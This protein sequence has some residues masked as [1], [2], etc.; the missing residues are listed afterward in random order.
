[1][2]RSCLTPSICLAMILGLAAADSQA[3]ADDVDMQTRMSIQGSPQMDA[4]LAVL[5]S[6]RIDAI[7]A[8]VPVD[9]RMEADK[10]FGRPFTDALRQGMTWYLKQRGVRIVE[11]GEDLRLV[12]NIVSYEGW[13]GW[14]H[15]GV[16]LTLEMRFFRG[17]DLVWTDSLRSY[18][19]Y[20]DDEDVEDE[21]RA[22]YKSHKMRASFAEILFTRV[23]MD[24]SEKLL[25]LLKEKA[26][27]GT[28][29]TKPDESP[30]ADRGK[31]SIEAAVRNAEV[32]IDGHL[33]GMVPVNDLAL[34]AGS[35]VMEV[36]KS[37]F[38]PWKREFEVISGSSTRFVAEMTPEDQGKSVP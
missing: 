14:G 11:Q 26:P 24:L 33:V 31:V 10:A 13:K 37:G 32:F 8:A 7:Q 34:D 16:D 15:W 17:P 2:E 38:R 18:L 21:E 12:G 9:D 36:R 4:G 35:H 5:P 1:M 25:T 22:K 28:V 6:L 29:Q 19:K 30:L 27:T 3:M 20:A 23:G